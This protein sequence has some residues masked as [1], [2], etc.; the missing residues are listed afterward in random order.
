[1]INMFELEKD[2][3]DDLDYFEK[4]RQERLE[5]IKRIDALLGNNYVNDE[6]SQYQVMGNDAKVEDIKNEI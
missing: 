1:M 3:M 6:K 4:D 2:F 5:T